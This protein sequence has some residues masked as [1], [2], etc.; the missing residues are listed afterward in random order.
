MCG[1][2]KIVPWEIAEVPMYQEHLA[3]SV[4]MHDALQVILYW[5]LLVVFLMSVSVQCAV[6]VW[7][8]LP[9]WDPPSVTDGN[10]NAWKMTEEE[11]HC[12]RVC[13]LFD[14][15]ICTGRHNVYVIF[16]AASTVLM[17]FHHFI[18]YVFFSVHNKWL[19]CIDINKYW[20]Y[21]NS[22]FHIIYW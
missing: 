20:L 4:G 15:W 19:S 21:N 3:F 14:K 5:P 18:D 17:F 22:I 9:V 7:L 6:L 10:S 11:E 16:G 1:A 12:L 2:C 13:L 8:S